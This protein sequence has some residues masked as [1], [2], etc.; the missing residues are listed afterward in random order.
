[1]DQEILEEIMDLETP[2]TTTRLSIRQSRDRFMM[3]YGQA[4]ID[5]EVYSYLAAIPH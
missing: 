5:V 1:M 4:V 3:Y 2:M